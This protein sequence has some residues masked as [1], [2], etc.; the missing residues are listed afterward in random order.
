ML[1]D[2][3]YGGQTLVVEWT[4]PARDAD[5]VA[6]DTLLIAID[7][8]PAAITPLP[9]HTELDQAEGRSPRSGSIGAESP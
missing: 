2:P 4:A 7:R 5:G 6:T 8:S 1:T 9:K 3:E